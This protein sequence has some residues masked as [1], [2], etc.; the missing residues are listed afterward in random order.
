MATK[1]AVI[2]GGASF[3]LARRDVSKASRRVSETLAVMVCKKPFKG[4][5]YTFV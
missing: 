4:L 3:C 5:R 1:V 2:G